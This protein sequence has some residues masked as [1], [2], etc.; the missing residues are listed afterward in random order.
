MPYAE[1]FRRFAWAVVRPQSVLI[2]I[3]YGF[4]DDHVVSI[5]R[6]A[7]TVPSFRLIIVDPNPQSQVVAKLR[8]QKDQRIWIISGTHLGKFGGFIDQVLPD[9][10]EEEINKK[11]MQTYRVLSPKSP[12]A[13]VESGEGAHGE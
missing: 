12:A 11:A 3:G 9:L 2:V 8:E 7:I 4:A 13:E 5:I 10:R 1:L 6:Q